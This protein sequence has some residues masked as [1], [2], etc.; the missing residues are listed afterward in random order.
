[1]ALVEV[2]MENR[3]AVFKAP[4]AV[5]PRA[6]RFAEAPHSVL[7]EEEHGKLP[8]ISLNLR[9]TRDELDRLLQ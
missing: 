8:E 5:F 6:A 4:T 7:K 1:M 2:R 3:T 9:I